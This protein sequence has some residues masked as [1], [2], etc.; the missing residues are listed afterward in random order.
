[1]Q[2][3]GL[4]NTLSMQRPFFLA[5]FMVSPLFTPWFASQSPPAKALL[6]LT[7]ATPTYTFLVQVV[8]VLT[9][10]RYLYDDLTYNHSGLHYLHVLMAQVIPPIAFPQHQLLLCIHSLDCSFIELNLSQKRLVDTQL[11]LL[12]IK[13]S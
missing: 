3:E 4:F 13:N 5:F 10:M 8:D 6:S 9:D 7:K 1:M 11:L 2:N 12:L